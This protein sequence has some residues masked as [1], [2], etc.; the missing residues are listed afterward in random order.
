[1]IEGAN[2]DYGCHFGWLGRALEEQVDFNDAVQSVCTWI[3]ANGGWDNNLL[4]VTTD[5]ETGGLWGPDAG[6]GTPATPGD[7][8]VYVPLV[9]NGK[10]N[11]PG[12]TFYNHRPLYETPTAP[13]FWHS[14]ALVPLFAKGSGASL[15]AGQ[16]EGMDPIRG[17]YID[18]TS[19]FKVMRSSILLGTN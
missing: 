1:M 10:G 15:F 7:A 5:H 6:K 4:I 11:L 14:N 9:N 8:A 17:R 18:N 12:A 16:V 13:F 3:E 19:I 2:T